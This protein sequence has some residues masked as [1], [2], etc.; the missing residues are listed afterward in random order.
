MVWL[1]AEVCWL[2][3]LIVRQQI[4][5]ALGSA[6]RLSMELVLGMMVLIFGTVGVYFLKAYLAR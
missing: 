3:A 2:F 5:V 4:I 6:Q 1:K